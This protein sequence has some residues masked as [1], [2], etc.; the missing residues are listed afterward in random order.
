MAD[1]SKQRMNDLLNL[2][3]ANGF[4]V[5]RGFDSVLN[6]DYSGAATRY[7]LV[8]KAVERIDFLAHDCLNHGPTRDKKS[9]ILVLSKCC[10]KLTK[11]IR[12]GK[13]SS[14]SA[15]IEQIAGRDIE[16]KATVDVRGD[17][18]AMLKDTVAGLDLA[19]END[20]ESKRAPMYKEVAEYLSDLAER[21]G[22]FYDN[23]SKEAAAH[24][25]KTYEIVFTQIRRP[26]GSN[27]L[28]KTEL[29]K[30]K[31][32][33]NAEA[34][35]WS[36]LVRA[37]RKR[38]DENDINPNISKEDRGGDEWFVALTKVKEFLEKLDQLAISLE[39]YKEQTYEECEVPRLNYEKKKEELQALIASTTAKLQELKAKV[40][41]KRIT[42]VQAKPESEELNLAIKQAEQGVKVVSA[43]IRNAIALKD[44]RD[45]K[46]AAIK[47][48]L[49]LIMSNR[50]SPARLFVFASK[51]DLERLYQFLTSIA[52]EEET[53]KQFASISRIYDLA[54]A[55]TRM[56][57]AGADALQADSI[58][59]T[60]RQLEELDKSFANSKAIIEE[61]GHIDAEPE[62][63]DEDELYKKMFGEL[64]PA[65][66]TIDAGT[67]E[68][69]DET[70]NPID[71]LKLK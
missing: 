45:K 53:K 41:A 20:P 65:D 35:A 18:L 14:I 24:S 38:A 5:Q 8:C 7:D 55:I 22:S 19:Y 71:A 29:N 68:T 37:K 28:T 6:V 30:R 66:N 42:V 61:A 69:V 60:N 23:Y 50:K 9:D 32:E 11:S 46:Y 44:R 40:D 58:K 63:V 21:I 27:A 12:P 59:R 16:T 49:D 17:L 34:D 67:G 54:E 15:K 36:K 2:L 57:V 1:F 47:E 70:L 43:K 62:V 52:N 4:K 39:E 10:V 31:E 33:L 26:L 51:L 48:I 64:P 13:Q 25:R 56:E 3:S